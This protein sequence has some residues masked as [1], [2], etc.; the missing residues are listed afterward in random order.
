LKI[1]VEGTVTLVVAS[2]QKVDW[3]KA[4]VV[5][6]LNIEK[7]KALVKDDKL[8]AKKLIAFLDPK[9]S[10]SASTAHTEVK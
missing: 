5:N 10:A 1:G 3:A 9:S 4:A 7:W 8:Y 6:G 2:G